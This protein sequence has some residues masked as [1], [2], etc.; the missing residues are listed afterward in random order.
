MRGEGGGYSRRRGHEIGTRRMQRFIRRRRGQS[1][2]RRNRKKR[3]GIGRDAPCNERERE[4]E[5]P[6]N[7]GTTSSSLLQ[8]PFSF[9]NVFAIEFMTGGGESVHRA[10]ER[11]RD[12]SCKVHSGLAGLHRPPGGARLPLSPP[13]HPRASAYTRVWCNLRAT[14]AAGAPALSCK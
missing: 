4:R 1:A 6:K 8:Q 14:S 2:K 5:R 13:P 12:A 7:L 10:R 9:T 3:R 11:E